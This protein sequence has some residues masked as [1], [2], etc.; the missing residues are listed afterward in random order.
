MEKFT[1]EETERK[2][3]LLRNNNKSIAALENDNDILKNEN[4]IIK[5]Q[6][7]RQKEINRQQEESLHQLSQSGAEMNKQILLSN[8]MAINKLELEVVKFRN[9][10]EI[11]IQNYQKIEVESEINKQ[12]LLD[13]ERKDTLN[14]FNPQEKEVLE[15]YRYYYYY[16]YY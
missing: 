13:Y 15:L 4:N 2:N 8:Q 14:S 3:L 5:E 6:L 10:K 16:D 7:D 1:I 11:L 12:K 9:E